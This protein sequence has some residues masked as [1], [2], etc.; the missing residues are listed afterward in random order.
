MF[1]RQHSMSAQQ[2]KQLSGDV[3]VLNSL[4]S[5]DAQRVMDLN[6]LPLS[7]AGV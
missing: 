1:A 3:G 6:R 4:W 7:H 2:V 5:A